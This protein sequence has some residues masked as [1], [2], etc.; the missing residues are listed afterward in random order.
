MRIPL[1]REI[2]CFIFAEIFL[3]EQLLT[4]PGVNGLL[5]SLR[6]WKTEEG[7][8]DLRFCGEWCGG[9]DCWAAC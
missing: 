1:S 6:N 9:T 5:K 7:G 4:P 3:I 2:Q 8:G